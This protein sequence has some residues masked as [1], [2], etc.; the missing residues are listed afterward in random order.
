MMV[1]REG[2]VDSDGARRTK[3]KHS[4]GSIRGLRV[5]PGRFVWQ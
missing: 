4:M 2:P 5:S 3:S 1:L